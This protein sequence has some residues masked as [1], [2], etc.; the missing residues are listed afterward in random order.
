MDVGRH[1][2]IYPNIEGAML[3][4]TFIWIVLTKNNFDFNGKHYL[5]V[6]GTAM[7]TR[8]APTYAN[9]LMASLDESKLYNNRLQ[10]LFG[11]HL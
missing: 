8:V 6:G 3:I 5:Q 1:L 9:L 10:P 7:G 11:F 4:Y 2:P